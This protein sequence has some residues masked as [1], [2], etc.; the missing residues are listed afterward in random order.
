MLICD[1]VVAVQAAAIACT[2]VW[3]IRKDYGSLLGSGVNKR[4]SDYQ[5]IVFWDMTPAV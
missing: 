5:P 1:V 2:I 4:F 3:D